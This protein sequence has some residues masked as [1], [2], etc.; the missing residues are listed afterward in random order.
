MSSSK[1][2][3]KT[4][5]TSRVILKP[6]AYYKIL[7]HALRWGSNAMDKSYYKECMGMLIGELGE[8]SGEIK[9]VIVH[10]YVPINHGGKI[11]VA[12]APED[13]ISF[14]YVDADYAD[15]GLFTVGWAHTHPGLTSFLSDVDIRN[16]LGFQTP[17][18]SAIALVFDHQYLEE[19]GNMGFKIFRLD[20]PNQGFA[21]E[22]HE[23]DWLIEPPES[24][25]F[26]LKIKEL[27]E[28]VQSKSPV[29]T[30]INETPD[31][32]GDIQLPGTNAMRSKLPEMDILGITEAFNKGFQQVANLFLDPLVR[33]LNQF[34][35]EVTN[36]VISGNVGIIEG[37]RSLKEAMNKGIEKLQGWFKLALLE[38]FDSVETYIEHRF[39]SVG[40]ST[41]LVLELVQGLEKSV[42]E[43]LDEYFE[44]HLA[45]KIADLEREIT[46]KMQEL[47][48]VVEGV[49]EIDLSQQVAALE[50]TVGLVEKD[51]GELFDKLKT[52]VTGMIDANLGEFGDSLGS[53]KTAIADQVTTISVIKR[54]LDSMKE[55]VQN[56]KEASK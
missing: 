20:D 13:Y 30:E 17:N 11:E 14:S 18:P 33:Y 55:D 36:E 48:A 15:K 28:A 46:S 51:P 31:V 6:L 43:G 54:V 27:I 38:K 8:G 16:Q 10:D 49:G 7:I 45:Q 56:L 40:K 53:I 21:S 44:N 25:D 3:A 4:K 2:S 5:D 50:G 32:F 41:G 22:Y 47:T 37:I 39:E 26:Y 9:D 34:A 29:I 19:E 52:S 23:V 42:R 12:F 35:E 1:D 24:S